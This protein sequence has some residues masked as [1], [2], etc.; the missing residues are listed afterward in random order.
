MKENFQNSR[1]SNDIDMKVG[2]VTK[3]D[4]RNKTKS[5]KFDDDAMSKNCDVIVI[6]L[7]YD[8]F[9]AIQKPDSRHIV[10]KT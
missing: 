8:Q 7:I 5:Q 4:K 9:G 6:F 2:P 3:V 1:T 10:C